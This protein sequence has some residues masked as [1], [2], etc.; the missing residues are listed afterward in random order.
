VISLT[1]NPAYVRSRP[2]FCIPSN[3]KL[4]AADCRRR[5]RSSSGATLSEVDTTCRGNSKSVANLLCDS[6][7]ARDSLVFLSPSRRRLRR[8]TAGSGWLKDDFAP[9]RSIDVYR[10]EGPRKFRAR[11]NAEFWVDAVQVSAHRAMG[12]EQPIRDLPIG[13]AFRRHLGDL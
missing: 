7:S 10:R 13:E 4:R 5:F 9:L 12:E 6:T 8:L 1:Q 11:H 2:T 3:H